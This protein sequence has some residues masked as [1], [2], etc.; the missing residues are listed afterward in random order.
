[1]K[2]PLT[3]GKKKKMASQRTIQ[4]RRHSSLSCPAMMPTVDLC[5][6]FDLLLLILL[7]SRFS[8][9]VRRTFIKEV[10]KSQTSTFL[11]TNLIIFPTT[12]P[13]ANPPHP[14]N[15]HHESQKQLDAIYGI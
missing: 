8:H 9:C 7:V 3:A 10:C 14:I 4:L 15:L 12:V 2:K 1:M 5:R 13:V 11:Q 6:L